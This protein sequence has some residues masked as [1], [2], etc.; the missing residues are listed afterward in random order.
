MG[1]ILFEISDKKENEPQLVKITRV[2]DNNL[3]EDIIIKNDKQFNVDIEDKKYNITSHKDEYRYFFS[4][5]S[6]HEKYYR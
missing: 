3:R 6:E 4:K 2:Y 1:Y 5:T